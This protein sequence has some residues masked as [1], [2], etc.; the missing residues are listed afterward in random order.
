MIADEGL[1]GMPY[2]AITHR[3]GLQVQTWCIGTQ[4]GDV[5]D[6]PGETFQVVGI[7]GLFSN[8]GTVV[9]IL[10]QSTGDLIRMWFDPKQVI[11]LV[12]VN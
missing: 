1:A 7:T 5:T 9:T 3:I 11:S 6:F 12:S 2:Q 4:I 8:P 10:Q